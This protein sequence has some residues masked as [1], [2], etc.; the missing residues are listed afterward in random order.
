M[1]E[2]PGDSNSSWADDYVDH[3][4]DNCWVSN[5]SDVKYKQN[6]KS[7]TMTQRLQVGDLVRKKYGT[8]TIEVMHDYGNYF[9][10][11]YVHSGASS[12]RLSIGDVVRVNEQKNETEQGYGK[13]KGKLFQTKDGRFGIGLAVNSA[14]K[15]VLEM[16]GTGDLVAYDKSEVELVMPFTYNVQFNGVGTEYSYLG[17]EGT[18]KVDDLLLKT[19]GSKGIV[20]AKVTAINTKSEKA[21]KYFDGVKIVTESLEH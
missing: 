15:Y 1:I 7:K 13:M 20:I 9:Y 4:I 10:G 17:K 21:T 3:L 2:F 14:G 12:G 18:V 19:D 11:R 6:T 8:K 16:K 5:Y